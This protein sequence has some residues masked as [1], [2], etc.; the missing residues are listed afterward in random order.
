MNLQTLQILEG[1]GRQFII[2]D[3]FPYFPEPQPASTCVL[4]EWEQGE[5]KQIH[6]TYADLLALI[7]K[8]LLKIH[9][10]TK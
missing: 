1:D 7:D 10:K 9:P 5:K 2:A 3:I 4:I 6:R 8:G